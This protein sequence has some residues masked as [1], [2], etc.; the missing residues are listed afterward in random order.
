LKV[1]TF[2]WDVS[3]D[4]HFIGKTNTSNLTK[5]GIRLFRSAGVNTGTNTTL[6]WARLK[7]RRGGPVTDFLATL[8]DELLNCWHC[9]LLEFGVQI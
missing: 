5:R 9:Y 7:G 1:V 8:A 2:T 4:F 3:G 6:L